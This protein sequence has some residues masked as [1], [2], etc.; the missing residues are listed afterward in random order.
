MLWKMRYILLIPLLA[1]PLIISAQEIPLDAIKVSEQIKPYAIRAHM[2]FLADDLLE[3]RKPFT[4]G[5]RLAAHYVATE[6]EEMGL[7]PAVGDSSY[8]QMVELFKNRST[9]A[10]TMDLQDNQETKSLIPGKDFILLS[11]SDLID[12]SEKEIIFGGI[13]V[14]DPSLGY[15]DLEKLNVRNKYVILYYWH[16]EDR[17]IQ[18]SLKHMHDERLLRLKKAGA[19]GVIFFI[20]KKSQERLSWERFKYYFGQVATKSTYL[21]FPVFLIDWKII[22]SLF[23]SNSPSLDE[24]DNGTALPWQYRLKTSLRPDLQINKD[25]EIRE[26]RNV[27]AYLEGSDPKLKKEF[28]VYTAHLDHEGIGRPMEGDSIY[29]GAYDNAAGMAIM[30]EI[31]R[32]YTELPKPPRRSVLFIALTAEEMGLLG[33]EYFVNHPTI[34]LDEM[35]ASLNTDMFLMEQP[36]TEMAALGEEFSGLGNLVHQVGKMKKVSIIPDPLPEENIFMRS[37]HFNF[38]KKGI[39]SLFIINNFHKS[40]SLND[41]S[42]ANYR[43]LKTLYHTPLDNFRENIH[44]EAGVTYAQINFLIGY[45]AAEQ[46]D[47]IRWNFDFEMEDPLDLRR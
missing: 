27:L 40:D 34:P 39:P 28:I 44:Y 33:S 46:K 2:R 24:Y 4:R 19:A 37:D 14:Q 47:R 15:H 30:L 9:L 20:P 22:N 16:P 41:N 5:Y 1:L 38:V 29:N 23:E 17:S 31:A 3:G 12:P 7:I 36:F 43:W 45:L 35:V 18:L 8:Y 32:A 13:G 11:E 26:S 21:D 25:L 6:F 42:D 10:G